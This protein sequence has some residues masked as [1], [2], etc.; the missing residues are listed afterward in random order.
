[1]KQRIIFFITFLVCSSIASAQYSRSVI[2][3]SDVNA[4]TEVIE[5]V[6]KQGILEYEAKELKKQQLKDTYN[7]WKHIVML[8]AD[9][10]LINSTS[11]FSYG[12]TYAYVKQAGFYVSFATNFGPVPTKEVDQYY[13][14]T[15]KG[16]VSKYSALVGGMVALGVPL[17]FKAGVG[18]AYYGEYLRTTDNECLLRGS[19]YTGGHN[20][21]VEFGFLGHYKNVALSLTCIINCDSYLNDLGLKIGVGYCF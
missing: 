21:A 6:N 15:G 5:E 14:L 11:A 9:F 16:G 1:M 10:S 3:T 2:T 4:V 7:Y 8:N 20:A 19:R 17:Y 18:Y 12:A 13:F